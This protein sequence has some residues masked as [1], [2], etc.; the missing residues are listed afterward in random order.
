MSIDFPDV[1]THKIIPKTPTPS[2]REQEFQRKNKHI[3]GSIERTNKKHHDKVYNMLKSPLGKYTTTSVAKSL[4]PA[5]TI[6]KPTGGKKK[7]K[8]NKK[9]NRRT[10]K[11]KK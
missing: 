7:S 3:L 5:P 6:K 11:Q 9:Q 8:K 2:L 4:P 1:P 10:R